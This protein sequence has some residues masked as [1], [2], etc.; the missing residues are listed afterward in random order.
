MSSK[1]I[2]P[3]LNSEFDHWQASDVWKDDWC[4]Y[5]DSFRKMIGVRELTPCA[6]GYLITT[7]QPLPLDFPLCLCSLPAP[8]T[9]H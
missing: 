7:S 8:R 4:N 2:F 3:R 5:S 9:E 6:D 1:L